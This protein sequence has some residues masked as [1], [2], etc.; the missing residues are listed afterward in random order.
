MDDRERDRD[1]MCAYGA[2]DVQ[3]FERLYER[4]KGPL[5]RYFVRQCGQAETAEE[6]FQEV[7]SKIIKARKTYKP[8]AKFT[9]WMYQMAHNCLIDH[10]RR[11]QRRPRLVSVDG[12]DVS[13]EPASDNPGPAE[14]AASSEIRRMFLAV[15]DQLPAEQREAFVLREEVGMSLLEIADATG[16][17]RETVKSRLRYALKKLRAALGDKLDTRP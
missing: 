9:T 16:V 14:L 17:G 6:L 2:G 13:A 4:H 10:Y 7:W 8:L 1:L 11:T 12:E 3:A 5:Y 15:L